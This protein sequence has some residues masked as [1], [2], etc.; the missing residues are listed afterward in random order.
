MVFSSH[1]PF[2]FEEQF[3]QSFDEVFDNVFNGV[4]PPTKEK[5]QIQYIEIELEQGHN[6][7][8]KKIFL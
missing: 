3:D 5:K 8:R 2:E 6:Q 1:N 4:I 7:L